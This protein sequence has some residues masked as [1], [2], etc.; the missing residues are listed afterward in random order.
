MLLLVRLRALF[1]LDSSTTS[2]EG[3]IYLSCHRSPYC[4]IMP[5]MARFFLLHLFNGGYVFLFCNF[6]ASSKRILL[7]S[8]LI[9]SRSIY[10]LSPSCKNPKAVSRNHHRSTPHWS[11]NSTDLA[12]FITSTSRFWY[13]SRVSDDRN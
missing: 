2:F 6:Q 11:V 10:A 4:N 3:S 9:I 5:I 1:C 7:S 13:P 12:D 8:S